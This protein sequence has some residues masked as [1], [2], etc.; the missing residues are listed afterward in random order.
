MI[1]SA[2]LKIAVVEDD[3]GVRTA[4]QQL[5]RSAGFD[6]ETFESA[7]DFLAHGNRD[8]FA[9][10]IAD[11][12]LPGISGVDLVRGLSGEG[13]PLPA[14]L[15]TGRRDAATIALTRQAGDVPQLYK[16]FSDAALFEVIDRVMR[17]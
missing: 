17:Q 14:V 12:N 5:L 13:R 1:M 6:A 10:L 11:V 16:P 3:A 2:E 9:C 15:I 7:E 8:G 4:L